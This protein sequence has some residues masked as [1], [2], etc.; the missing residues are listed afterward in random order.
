MY[1]SATPTASAAADVAADHVLINAAA[2]SYII[3]GNLIT[4]PRARTSNTYDSG[5]CSDVRRSGVSDPIY[6]SCAAY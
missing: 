5:D 6:Y 2:A 3:R 4:H 1:E